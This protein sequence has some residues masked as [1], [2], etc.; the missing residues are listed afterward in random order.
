MVFPALILSARITRESVAIRSTRG[1]TFDLWVPTGQPFLRLRTTP[2]IPERSG[3]QAFREVAD[4]LVL[5]IVRRSLLGGE[6]VPQALSGAAARQQAVERVT[7]GDDDP[8]RPPVALGP[9][10]RAAQTPRCP[11]RPLLP[12]RNLLISPP[13]I[14][15]LLPRVWPR[16]PCHAVHAGKND[17]F[18]GSR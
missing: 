4:A 11:S 1:A 18:H 6:K 13:G 17:E 14:W 16:S 12:Y 2:P 15:L 8:E 9:R 5:Q 10:R 7:P 3:Q